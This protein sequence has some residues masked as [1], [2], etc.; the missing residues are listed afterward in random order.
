M[1]SSPS[2]LIILI[3]FSA[4]FSGLEIAFFSLS[5]AKIEVLIKQK[6]KGAKK[7]KALKNNPDKLLITI[8]VGNNIVN[9]A[10][11][12]IATI[13]ATKYFGNNGT[14]IAIGIMTI[15]ILIFGEITPKS[16]ATR[17]AENIARH[18][19]PF[20]QFL[21][22]VLFPIIWIFT[23]FNQLITRFLNK[24]PNVSEEEIQALTKIG[25]KEGILEKHEEK[26]IQN[27]LEFDKITVEQIM[28]PRVDI[29][30]LDGEKTLEDISDIIN[31]GQYS[32]YPIY[33]DNVDNI[34]GILHIRKIL[35]Y[36]QKDFSTI[37]LKDIVNTALFIPSTKY[38]DDLFREMKVKRNHMAIVTDEHGGTDGLITMEDIIEELVGNISDETDKEEVLI[39][40]KNHN[41][42][43]VSGK[44]ELKYLSED[45]N[46][47]FEN[48]HTTI[49]AFLIE[50]LGYIPKV[51][52]KYET[53]KYEMEII[54]ASHKLIE[55][56][57]VIK[58][59]E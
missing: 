23:K 15:L 14:G 57:Q 2:L 39:T 44:I 26:F 50:K 56:V 4:I 55:L 52:E 32:R 34:I 51:G 31:E 21:Q 24:A 38:I 43:V 33:I 46:L 27:I 28:I 29:V 41:T 35:K 17:Y 49:R 7:V 58:K 30:A 48:E 37:K 12:A 16:I 47:N 10:A 18:L 25:L 5:D 20:V 40:Q 54:S 22:W 9:S 8:L 53:E 19:A 13:M 6:L 1:D 11:S 45:T 36:L 3:V 59:D 42:W